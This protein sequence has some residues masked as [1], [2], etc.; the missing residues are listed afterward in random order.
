MGRFRYTNK[1][2]AEFS[3]YKLLAMIVLDRQSSCTNPYSPLY[4]RLQRLYS[5]LIKYEE[6]S[7]EDNI[8]GRM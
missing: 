4:K 6:L 2:L 1:E 8:T 7:T 5:Q 3:D